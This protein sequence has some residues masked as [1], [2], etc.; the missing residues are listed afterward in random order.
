MIGR[1]LG[2]SRMLT[3]L[4]MPLGA[5]SGAALAE[6]TDPRAVFAVAA[7]AKILEVAIALMTPI[8]KL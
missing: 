4:A 2:F 5:M 8:R 3:R 1:V 6:W 7:G